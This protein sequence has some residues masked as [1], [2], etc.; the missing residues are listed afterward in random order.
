M[1]TYLDPQLA[2]GALNE[3]PIPQPDPRGNTF[4]Q[5][6]LPKVPNGATS[7]FNSYEEVPPQWLLEQ[8]GAQAAQ[9]KVID[10]KLL[11]YFLSLG[12]KEN[13]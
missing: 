13:I 12:R 1:P 7:P 4:V 9:G 8:K 2:A 5:R 3:V 10:P 6:A 11:M